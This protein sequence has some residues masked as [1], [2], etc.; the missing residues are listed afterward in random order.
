MPDG[1]FTGRIVYDVT[2]G[3]GESRLVRE[4][5][6]AGCLALDGLPMLVA[7][8]ERQFEWWTGQ[9]P[10]PG[11]MAAAAGGGPWTVG[12]GPVVGAGSSR[13]VE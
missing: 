2:Y 7:Q 11:V 12:S 6:A 5:R 3:P 8:A 1:P 10:R 4:A 9:R 13:P